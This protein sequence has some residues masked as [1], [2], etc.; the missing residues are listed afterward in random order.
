MDHQIDKRTSAARFVDADGRSGRVYPARDFIADKGFNLGL[1]VAVI[2]RRKIA[3][4][5]RKPDGL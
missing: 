2:G 5:E 3:H 1:G 4:T